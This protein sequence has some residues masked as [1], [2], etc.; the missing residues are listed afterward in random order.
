MSVSVTPAWRVFQAHRWRWPA[1]AQP[2]NRLPPRTVV[3]CKVSPA[4]PARSAQAWQR[5]GDAVFGISEAAKGVARR[6]AGQSPQAMSAQPRTCSR[7]AR[8]A[9]TTP[10]VEGFRWPSPVVLNRV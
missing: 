3:P 2:L 10:L 7:P 5:R 1:R 4:N 9:T 8:G 6:A